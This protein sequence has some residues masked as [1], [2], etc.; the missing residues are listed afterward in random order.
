MLDPRWRTSPTGKAGP[1][2]LAGKAGVAGAGR[3]I[4]GGGGKSTI[5]WGWSRLDTPA[6]GPISS[7]V[8]PAGRAEGVNKCDVV[9]CLSCDETGVMGREAPG[10][11]DGL[12]VEGGGDLGVVDRLG[13][14][15]VKAGRRLLS[16]APVLRGG[17]GVIAVK[18]CRARRT[19]GG[20]AAS[21]VAWSAEMAVSDRMAKRS[22]AV[23]SCS[24]ATPARSRSSTEMSTS[25][26]G[27]SRPAA[28]LGGGTGARA[29]LAGYPAAAGLFPRPGVDGIAPGTLDPLG[30]TACCATL[31][32]SV[33]VWSRPFS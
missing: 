8:G 9:A 10:A 17:G 26:L 28:P 22:L 21:G 20:V 16:A 32:F 25:H 30:A 2:R 3:T 27:S 14:L 18:Y 5:C 12:P 23:N 15:R 11:G 1:A 19:D 29:G 33:D 24:T 13:P 6:S 4:V 7:P 31:R